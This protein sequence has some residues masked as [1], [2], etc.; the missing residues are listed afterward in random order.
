LF[1]FNKEVK[2]FKPYYRRLEKSLNGDSYWC[3]P[4]PEAEKHEIQANK[5]CILAASNTVVQWYYPHQLAPIYGFPPLYNGTGQKVAFIELGGGFRQPDLNLYFSRLGLRSPTVQFVSVDGARNRPSNAYS[6]DGEVMLDLCTTI[7]LANGI[8]PIVYMAPNSEQGFINAVNKAVTDR[9][10]IISISWGAPENQWTQYGISGMNSAFQRAASANITVTVASGDSGSSDGGYGDNV[11]F[12]A[13]SPY[14]LG[15][16]GTT[17]SSSGST[18]LSE[19][20]WNN[21]YG[22]TGGG[23]SALFS[24]P[25]WQN[26][27]IPTG[28]K[29][30]VPDVSGVADPG[31]GIKVIVD[32]GLYIFGG[33]STVSPIWAAYV[34][35]CN[36]AAR[37][38]LGFINPKLYS[39][40]LNNFNDIVSGNNGT[41][42]AKTGWDACT[43]LGSIKSSLFNNLIR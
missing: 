29:R 32:G 43:G 8:T 14:V 30:G 9:V 19:T 25:V 40:N 21:G 6:D 34:A 39:L 26:S 31:T 10:N 18:W 37:R 38:S 15:C 27:A 28:N 17:L 33:T 2:V 22:A 5:S 24:K 12:P 41:Y 20:V 23:N 42:T 35:R 3:Y 11:D 16:G 7:G 4:N 36:Q 1:N 13:S